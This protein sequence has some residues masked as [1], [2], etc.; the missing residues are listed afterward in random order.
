M[1]TLGDNKVG[2]VL[3]T[4]LSPLKEIRL[5]NEQELSKIEDINARAIRLAELNVE[6]G[7][8]ILL[9]NTVIMDAMKERGVTVHGCIFELANGKLRDLGFGSK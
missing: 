3:D 1:A 4:W 5:K 7:V 8:Q 2:G 9:A 6:R